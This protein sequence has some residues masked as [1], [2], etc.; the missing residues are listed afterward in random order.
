MADRADCLSA[1]MYRLASGPVCPRTSSRP[2]A[3]ASTPAARR[4]LAAPGRRAPAT[5][6]SS[7]TPRA[8]ARPSARASWRIPRRQ[9]MGDTLKLRLLSSDQVGTMREKCLV[10]AR[11]A[12]HEDR[13]RRRP[14]HPRRG[15][16]RRRSRDARR[17]VPRRARRGRARDRPAR[18]GRQGRRP[19]PRLPD[20]ASRGPVLLVHQHPEHAAP[21]RRH[22]S[23]SRTTRPPGTPSGARSSRSSTT[24]TSRHPDADGRA[25][26]ER[27]GPRAQHPDAEHDQAAVDARLQP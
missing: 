24:P 5:A 20:P 9:H 16:R 1:E 12:G 13:P 7:L 6:P 14:R 22:R 25:G 15:R 10:P 18:A 23:G 17:A 4:P 19:A 11:D 27:R 2:T 8:G 21:R 3:P 26:G